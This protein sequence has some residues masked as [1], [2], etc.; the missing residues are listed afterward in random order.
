MASGIKVISPPSALDLSSFC[1]ENGVLESS[2]IQPEKVQ[3]HKYHIV[4]FNDRGKGM[5]VR[6]LNF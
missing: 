2:S 5:E 3:S 1:P 4:Q 6:V